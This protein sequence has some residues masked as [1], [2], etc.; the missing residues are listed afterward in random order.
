MGSCEKRWEMWEDGK[1]NT[2]SWKI[3]V[4]M[5][6]EPKKTGGFATCDFYY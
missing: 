3:Y 5:G 4:W 2:Y 6:F 1:R